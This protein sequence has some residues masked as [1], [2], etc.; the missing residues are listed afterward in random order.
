MFVVGAGP[1]RPDRLTPQA[2]EIIASCRYVAGGRRL[3]A[4]APPD[5]ITC[6]IG[7]DL[8][9]VRRFI[10][11]NIGR[12]DV[13]VLTSG[14]PGCFSIL[15]FLKTHFPDRISVIP[16]I[17]SV[18]LMAARLSASWHD[19]RLESLHGRGRVP[20]YHTGSSPVLYF[21]DAGN[22]PQAVAL[23]LLSHADAGAAVGVNLGVEEEQL[24]QGT[25]SGVAR[26]EFPGNSLLLVFPPPAAE[27]GP[28]PATIGERPWAAAPGIPDELWIRKEGIPMSKSEFRAVLMARVQPAL[29]HT[30]WDV[31]SGTGTYAIESALLAPQAEVY[32]IDRNPEACRLIAANARRFGA[33]VK[34]ACGTA[35]ESFTG[36]PR[37]DLVVIGGN[38]G[39]LAEIFHEAVQFVQPGGRVAI[40][41][42]L[43]ATRSVAHKLLAASALTNRQAVRVA[44]A[45]AEAHEW[46]E[47]NPV[48]LFTGDKE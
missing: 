8:D 5:A 47:N 15:P 23:H 45:R 9:G 41:A 24:W 29:R 7:S 3:L 35:P 39:S 26:E 44:I 28:G 32:A 37:P 13:A 36:L 34:I 40:T 48:I 2:R 42:V 18:Q 21:C 19:W 30:I 14:D 33:E 46:I 43:E 4:L 12:S 22:S 16:G 38:D 20:V 11:G 25:L 17:S 6:L 1:G 31:G 27:T 10:A